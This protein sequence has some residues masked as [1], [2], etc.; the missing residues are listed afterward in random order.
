MVRQTQLKLFR[1][2]G[3]SGPPLL[4]LLTSRNPFMPSLRMRS[5]VLRNLQLNWGQSILLRNF[6]VPRR[7][8]LGS[9]L[10]L[11]QKSNLL[12][13]RVKLFLPFIRT[14]KILLGPWQKYRSFS[15]LLIAVLFQWVSVFGE[16]MKPPALV[17]VNAVKSSR[18]CAPFLIRR[19]PPVK[20][21][22]LLSGVGIL[23]TVLF[24]RKRAWGANFQMCL[25]RKL[26]LF[27]VLTN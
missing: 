8:L 14:F 10:P 20:R 23:L 2:L 16:F 25:R 13:R 17:N 22:I 19:G 21:F 12:G 18:R 6:A 11:L 15:L 9:M 27:L 3:Q 26:T 7:A 24:P 5:V 1:S 4:L